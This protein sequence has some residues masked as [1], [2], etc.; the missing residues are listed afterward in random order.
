M[1][2]NSVVMWSNVACVCV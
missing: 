1:T 2:D